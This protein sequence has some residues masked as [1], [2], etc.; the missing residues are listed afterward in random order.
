MGDP[1]GLAKSD[2]PDGGSPVT[3]CAYSPVGGDGGGSGQGQ[4]LA[5]QR[6]GE[7]Q[8][9]CHFLLKIFSAVDTV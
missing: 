2:E 8:S 6:A 5:E 3:S 1:N 9:D 7:G 4:H